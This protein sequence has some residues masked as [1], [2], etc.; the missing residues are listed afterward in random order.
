M[1][2][3]IHTIR[4]RIKDGVEPAEALAV[5]ERFQREVAPTLPG[6]ER[7]EAAVAADGE[8][9]LINRYQTLETAQARNAASGPAAEAMMAM[10]DPTT[11]SSSFAT[12][13]SD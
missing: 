13:I 3:V 12:V 10:I 5:N 4:F 11:M 7:R 8:W 2:A 9:L 1:T 6:L